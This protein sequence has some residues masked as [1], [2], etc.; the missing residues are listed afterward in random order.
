MGFYRGTKV[1][2][3]LQQLFVVPWLDNLSITHHLPIQRQSTQKS[4]LSNSGYKQYKRHMLHEVNDT[5]DL[6][7][8]LWQIQLSSVDLSLSLSLSL[9]HTHTHT[10]ARTHTHTHTQCRLLQS[11]LSHISR[12]LEETWMGIPIYSLSAA[13][14]ICVICKSWQ[15]RGWSGID[16]PRV[17][18][19]PSW[20]CNSFC[21]TYQNKISIVK[22]FNLMCH[23]WHSFAS[24][25]PSH[26]FLQEIPIPILAVIGRMEISQK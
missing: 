8:V 23:Q 24:Q 16:K 2:T 14:D 11:S 22:E 7:L 3:K 25:S 5:P 18:I 26:T 13:L 19:Y 15:L 4:S 10:H 17:C 1:K 21:S 12:S 9:S 6:L 20:I